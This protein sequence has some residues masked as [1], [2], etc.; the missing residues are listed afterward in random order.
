MP[1]KTPKP[2]KPT[3]KRLYRSES[4]QVVAGVAGGLAQYFDIDST[5]VR[6]AFTFFFLAGGSGI[7][8]YILL[9]I[10]VPTESSL[11]SKD[12]IQANANEIKT[13]AQNLASNLNHTHKNSPNTTAIIIII[14]GFFFLF[15]NFGL[16]QWLDLGKLWP[17][18][19]IAL[20]IHLLSKK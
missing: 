6:I 20:G 13:K 15:S 2:S 11:K 10:V 17:L 19:I 3:P 12:Y 18:F 8:A 14:L 7:L 1:S 5:L 16:F 4:D 9:W